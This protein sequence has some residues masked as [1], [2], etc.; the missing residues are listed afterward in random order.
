MGGGRRRY[1]GAGLIGAFAA[2]RFRYFRAMSEADAQPAP[3][4]DKTD[5]AAIEAF[6]A[7]WE[8]SGGSESANFQMFANELCDLLGL[9]PPDPSQELNEYGDKIYVRPY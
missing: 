6:I 3:A 5:P 7:R 8:K 2:R 9:P 1:R 4:G